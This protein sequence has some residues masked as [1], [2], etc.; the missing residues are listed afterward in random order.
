MF[1]S[2]RLYFYELSAP[3][4]V[5]VL[6]SLPFSPLITNEKICSAII[7]LNKNSTPDLFGF[8]TFSSFSSLIRLL[9]QIFNNSFL[10]KQFTPI[11]TLA[12]IK[13]ISK[14]SKHK[15]LKDWK[16][17]ALLNTNCK[18]LSSIIS[19]RIKLIFNYT[20]IPSF[21]MSSNTSIACVTNRSFNNHLNILQPR[22]I[23]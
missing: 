19:T 12:L 11:Q 4:N 21:P 8:T 16:C 10:R 13:L 20:I 14:T 18:S 3:S 15:T 17:F 5:G 6:Q 23:L 7:T 1:C 2:F 22:A 9:C